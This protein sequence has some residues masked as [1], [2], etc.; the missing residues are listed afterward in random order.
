MTVGELE[1]GELVTRFIYSRSQIRISDLRPKPQAFNP[2]PHKELSVIHSTGLVDKQ[3]WNI[4]MQTV[5]TQ[6]GRSRIH[7]RADIR[8]HVFT[9]QR[10]CVIRNNDPFDRHTSVSGWPQ[11]KDADE[12]KQIWKQICLELSQHPTVKLALPNAST[13]VAGNAASEE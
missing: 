4:G 8:V 6:P 7:G 1:S 10:L 2:A 3:I 5:G 11:G 9:D 12:T 13:T